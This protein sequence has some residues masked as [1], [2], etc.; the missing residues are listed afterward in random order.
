MRLSALYLD[1]G[2]GVHLAA[3]LAMGLGIPTIAKMLKV[4]EHQVMQAARAVPASQPVEPQVESPARP[5]FVSFIEGHE[6]RRYT[7]YKDTVGVPTV[8]VGFNLQRGDAVR[9]LSNVG[10]NHQN[11]LRGARLSDEQIDT[12]LRHDVDVAETVARRL[13]PNFDEL[14]ADIQLVMVDM[15]F[16]LGQPRLTQF[17]NMLAAVRNNDFNRAADEM[18][19]SR[20]YSQVG[21]RSRELEQMMRAAAR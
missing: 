1:E 21:N 7:V 3:L 5:D 13:L 16:N 12:L 18:V 10:A 6:G 17:N 20:W 4:P 8:G 11:V 14:P 15:A 2:K 9:Q 19:D